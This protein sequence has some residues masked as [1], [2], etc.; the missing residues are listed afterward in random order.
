[1][2]DEQD[3]QEDA[4]SFFDDFIDVV[5]DVGTSATRIV[6]D[7]AIDLANVT[8]GFQFDDDMQSAKK[9]MSD[10]GIYS[11]ADAI[12]KNHYAF[13]KD[14][15]RDAKDKSERLTELYRQG[16]E[17]VVQVN[18]LAAQFS[19]MVDDLDVLSREW[20]DY[21]ALCKRLSVY[22]GWIDVLQA[23][24]VKLIPLSEIDNYKNNWQSAAQWMAATS[25]IGNGASALTGLSGIAAAARA[26]RLIKAT[27]VVQAAKFTKFA[28]VAGK[29]SLVLTIATVGLDIGLSVFEQEDR[30]SRLES[31]LR[32]VD[33]E[34]A[35]AV[36]ELAELDAKRDQLRTLIDKLMAAAGVLPKQG[37]SQW[38]AAEKQRVQT[39]KDALVTLEGAIKRAEAL[40]KANHDYSRERL[41]KLVLSS[42]P[43]LTT[44]VVNVVIDQVLKSL[45]VSA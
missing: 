38:Y 5:K 39:L 22:P 27:R 7:T 11:A 17:C 20:S 42:D 30:K 26:A 44:E 34:I 23:L 6:T 29:A 37:W 14:L 41:L 21:E 45:A 12:Q 40:V 8:T 16:D 13:L 33:E 28:S 25:L 9:A 3:S 15:E 18:N 1:L 4:M 31:Y 24:G 43:L 19:A 36:R 32:D 2:I 35:R 10:A